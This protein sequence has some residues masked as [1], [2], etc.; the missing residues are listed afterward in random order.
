MKP[1]TQFSLDI[2][3]Q[4][5]KLFN[6]AIDEKMAQEEKGEEEEPVGPIIM[7]MKTNV[8]MVKH[9]FAQDIY[10]HGLSALALIR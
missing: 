3:N 10:L 1:G 7:Q 8:S 6:E 4:V 5:V 9:I 2:L